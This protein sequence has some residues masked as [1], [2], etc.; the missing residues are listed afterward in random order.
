[1]IE[2][3]NLYCWISNITHVKERLTH[4]GVISLVMIIRHDLTCKHES[5][6]HCTAGGWKLLYR[7]AAHGMIAALDGCN[8]RSCVCSLVQ[9][10]ENHDHVHFLPIAQYR[11]IN[12]IAGFSLIGNEL[13]E[14]FGI[15]QRYAI[16]SHDY[17][18]PSREIS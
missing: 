11:E 13:I 14:L 2:N 10:L 18:S 12:L 5:A 6:N 1:M 8:L 16:N 3:K 7:I 17:I 9:N 15:Y 4:S